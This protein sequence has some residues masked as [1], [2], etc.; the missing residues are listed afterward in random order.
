M[1]SGSKSTR[2]GFG[3]PTYLSGSTVAGP[4]MPGSRENI[5]VGSDLD[6]TG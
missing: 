1:Q 2:S 5:T 6:S 3:T 4:I